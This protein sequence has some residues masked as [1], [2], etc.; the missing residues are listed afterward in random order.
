M[1][2]QKIKIIISLIIVAFAFTHCN[3]KQAEITEL[4]F[5]G[6]PLGSGVNAVETINVSKTAFR[7]SVYGIT[8]QYCSNCHTTQYPQHATSNFEEAHDILLESN[9]VDFALPELSS[10][11]LKIKGQSHGC[12]SNCDDNAEEMLEAIKAWKEAIDSVKAKVGDNNTEGSG[13]GSIDSEECT[14]IT[15]T[16]STSSEEAFQES[17]YKVTR[18]RCSS[19]HD[20]RFPNH[21]APDA[22]L[23]HDT[24][25]N[26]ISPVTNQKFVDLDNPSVSRL[27]TK[28]AG[29]HQGQNDASEIQTA[30]EEWVRLKNTTR[31]IAS[32]KAAN[33]V[34]ESDQGITDGQVAAS[35]NGGEFLASEATFVNQGFTLVG[36][37][38]LQPQDNLGN[39]NQPPQ[40]GD[41]RARATWTFNVDSPGT[42]E[43]L[44]EVMEGDDT[45]SRDS[46]W[47]GIDEQDYADWHI[48]G[49]ANF[50][51]VKATNT[52]DRNAV[53]WNLTTGVHTLTVA[54]REHETR[55]KR[56]IIR[57][58]G[59]TNEGGNAAKVLTFDISKVS[60]RAGAQL[61]LKFKIL[62]EYAY[63]VSE[64]RIKN[65]AGL[66]VKGL[67]IYLNGRT[68]PEY[69]TFNLIEKEILSQ[70]EVISP[71]SMIML[72][73]FGEE[74]DKVGIKFD[75]IQ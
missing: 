2:L 47:V 4:N 27:V 68:N 5:G 21:S 31:S 34:V 40:A 26:N 20:T 62:D 37:Y 43:V 64:V 1:N 44:G 50:S 65:G 57:P 3:E 48:P 24:I 38:F 45:G 72:K 41:N 12:W 19:C 46:F 30:I 58:V 53:T 69:S 51:L 59:S 25:L 14:P 49:V 73:E 29:G 16:L 15:I 28:I 71:Y 9:K 13:E 74:A 36:D 55:M 63:E 10:L 8:R 23:A 54:R 66:L 11:Y 35:E 6:G 67:K 39:Q 52:G 33:G 42:Y 32:C 61:E 75:V 17:L 60:G 7:N 70:D 18:A 56:I 22:Q